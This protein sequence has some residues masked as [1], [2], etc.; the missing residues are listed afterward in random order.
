MN[1]QEEFKQRFCI[2][3]NV[4][5]WFKND[6]FP[7]DVL[8]FFDEVI[9][10]EKNKVK[11][12]YNTKLNE[13]MESAEGIYEQKVDL[14]EQVNKNLSRVFYFAIFIV[15]SLFISYLLWGHL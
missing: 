10:E 11:R 4:K 8:K 3:L 9:E 2:D 12:F 15:V 13:A 6:I 7:D 14:E 1:Y 5:H